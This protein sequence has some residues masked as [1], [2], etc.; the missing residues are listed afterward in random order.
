VPTAEQY[1]EIAE[2]CRRIATRAEDQHER[3]ELL[4]IGAQWDRLADYKERKQAERT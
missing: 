3:E 2:Q 1:R 4:R